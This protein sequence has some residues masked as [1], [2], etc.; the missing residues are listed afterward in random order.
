MT[1]SQAA[2][3]LLFLSPFAEAPVRGQEPEPAE[4][5]TDR[6]DQTE[7]A[8]VVPVGAFQAE[9]GATF[10][11]DDDG[12]VRVDSL[13]VPGVLL[14]YGL[15]RNFELRVAWAGWIELENRFDG[16]RDRVDGA[17][18]PEIGAKLVLLSAA[19]GAPLDLA[20]LGHLTLPAGAD[21]FNSPRADPSLRLNG[22]HD[23]SSGIGLGWN[24]GYEAASFE[25]ARGDVHTLG[26]WIYTVA[27]GFDL[28]DEWGAFVELFGDFP[29]SDPEPA[30]HS[31]DAGV[32]WLVAPRVQLDFAAGV[33]LNDAA[34]DWFVGAG[35]SFRVPR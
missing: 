25:D 17:A 23:L 14:R 33:G 34:P 20:L 27:A 31:L 16:G 35:V 26:R 11:R 21:D 13:E 22:A 15:L 7:S 1:R 3:V 4:L 29:A 8:V 9:L 30:A 28:A 18:D 5:V 2:L 19:D 24:V 32:T 10:G 6:P 12:L